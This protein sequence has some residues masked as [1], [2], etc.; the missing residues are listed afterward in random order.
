M[1]GSQVVSVVLPVFNGVRYLSA[2]V[3][4]ILAQSFSEFE[5]II[6]DDGSTD[7][8][9]KILRRFARK[10]PRIRIITRANTGIVGALNEGIANCTGEFVFR[11]DADDVS[12]PRRFEVQ[13]AEMHRSHDCVALGSAVLFTDPEGR[14]LKVYRPS[15]MHSAIV[16]ELANGNGG[17]LIHPTVIFRREALL[18]CG[19]YRESFQFIEDL[20]LFVRLL[21]FGFLSNLPDVLLRYR[22]HSRS[23]NHV[24]GDFSK[25]RA[26]IVAPLRKRRGATEW[27][28]GVHAGE[29]ESMH[30]AGDLRRRWAFYAAEDGNVHSARVNALMACWKDPWD[31]RNWSC[32]RY[33]AGLRSEKQLA[34]L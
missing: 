17:A 12:L 2:A 29:D 32:F 26:E 1:P 25:Q 24:K 20:D 19:G 5:F 11:M 23:V 4:S 28:P 33:V 16:D 30:S 21:D 13:L 7:L 22:Q 31:R 8:S 18:R 6:V 3:E 27:A 10:D 9:L 34:G 14:P 15:G